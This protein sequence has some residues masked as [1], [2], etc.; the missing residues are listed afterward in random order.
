MEDDRDTCIRK[1]LPRYSPFRLYPRHPYKWGNI[2]RVGYTAACYRRAWDIPHPRNWILRNPHGY[3]QQYL[4]YT[5]RRHK[6][7]VSSHLH[8]DK[9][10]LQTHKFWA[11]RRRVWL[12]R[13][14]SELGLWSDFHAEMSSWPVLLNV[15]TKICEPVIRK[16]YDFNFSH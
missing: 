6:C 12:A 5:G 16:Q 11:L 14:V 13:L 15:D 3:I 4:E 9:P 7:P 1:G 8:L 10:S 2:A